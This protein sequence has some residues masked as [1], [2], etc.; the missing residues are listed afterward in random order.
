MSKQTHTQ[1]ICSPYKHTAC[2]LHTQTC[3]VCINNTAGCQRFISKKSFE[4][5]SS[6]VWFFYR[7]PKDCLRILLSKVEIISVNEELLVMTHICP[8][9]KWTNTMWASERCADHMQGAPL[10]NYRECWSALHCV[11]GRMYAVK[12]ILKNSRGFQIFLEV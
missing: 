11:V 8:N 6:A 2:W 5:Q 3:T 4:S 10:H 7:G 9:V 12:K 1:S